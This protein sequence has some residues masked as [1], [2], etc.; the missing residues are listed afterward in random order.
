MKLKK[1]RA[2]VHVID[3]LRDLHSKA[4]F[5]RASFGLDTVVV[6]E[7]DSMTADEFC[8]ERTRTYRQAWLLPQIDSLIAWAEGR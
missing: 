5:E 7:R 6:R 2:P 1:P 8:K 4:A 3:K